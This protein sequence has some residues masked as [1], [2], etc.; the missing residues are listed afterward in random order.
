MPQV[1]QVQIFPPGP[2]P[3]FSP[4]E[5]CCA[6]VAVAVEDGGSAV[7]RGFGQVGVG[8]ALG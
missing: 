7:Q 1:V 5:A 6:H 4:A 8:V 2:S 3:G